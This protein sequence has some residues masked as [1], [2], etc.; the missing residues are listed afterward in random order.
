[1]ACAAELAL[2]LVTSD[3]DGAAD[4]LRIA[5]LSSTGSLEAE[6][7]ERVGRSALALAD[8]ALDRA[9]GEAGAAAA[10]MAETDRLSLAGDVQ[11]QLAEVAA[12]AGRKDL[13]EDA[14][15]RA[16]AAYAAKGDRTGLLLLELVG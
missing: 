7:A 3:R 8:G 13:A 9:L 14:R 15:E 12:A 6:V 10:R 16:R 4:W 11:R 2:T 1:M 5:Q